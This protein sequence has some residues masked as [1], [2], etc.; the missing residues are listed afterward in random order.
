MSLK[1]D[2]DWPAIEKLLNVVFHD[3][4]VNCRNLLTVLELC[5]DSTD[6]DFS[7]KERALLEFL[8]MTLK[9][10]LELNSMV[11]ESYY[12]LRETIAIKRA[13]RKD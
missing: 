5:S 2:Q 4:E 1:E 7:P 11:N 12:K 8:E 3:E 9:G 13:N 10:R 6:C